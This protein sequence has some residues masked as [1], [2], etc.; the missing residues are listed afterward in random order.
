MVSLLKAMTLEEKIGQLSMRNAGDS[1]GYWIADGK[2]GAI[3]NEVDTAKL[4][5]YQQ[6][7]RDSSRLGIPLLTARDVIH[8]Y[9]TIFPVPLGQAAAWNP[10][11]VEIGAQV[12]A[13]EA[14]SQGINWTFA[15]MLDV[16]RDPRWGRVVESFGEDAYLGSLLSKAMVKGFQ[17]ND[18]S[19][20][21]TIAA[22][23][24][25]Y[26]AYGW[27]EGGRDYNTANVGLPTIHD[28]IL[29]PFVSAIDAGA[30]TVMTAFQDLNGIP[31]TGHPYWVGDYL[32]HDLG[33][34]GVVVSDWESIPQMVTHGYAA[35]NVE[36]AANAAKATV[37][38]EMQSTTYADHLAALVENGRVPLAVI[39]SA[40][41]R[42]LRLK[43]SLGLFADTQRKTSFPALLAPD[44][45]LAAQEMAT[46]SFILL[47]NKR[48]RLP[49]NTSLSVA[50]IG[51]LADAP[52]E[53][54]G[55]WVFDGQAAD[56]VTPLSAIKATWPADKVRYSPGLRISRDQ[57]KA[58]FAKAVAA[59][60]SA[61]VALL[62]LGEESIITGE[63][64]SRADI[65]LP[66]AQEDL[67]HAIAATGT[68]IV[69]VVL[70]G[71]PLTMEGWVDKVDALFFG[72]HPG[73]MTGPAI[74][75]LLTGAENPSGK[76][77][78]TF[79]KHVGQIP[80]YY[81]HTN[82]G[83]PATP[84]S[85]VSIQDIPVKALQTSVG[86]TSHYLDYGYQPAYTFGYGL[87][88]TTFAYS[89]L[90][91]RDTLL[92]MQD[93]LTV[94]VEV[95]NTGDR[96]GQTTAQLYIKDHVGSR[97]RPVRSLQGFQKIALAPG[98]KQELTFQLPVQQLSFYT[99]ENKVAV[100]PGQFTLYI[101]EDAGA[102]L[103]QS[104]TVK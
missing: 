51:P 98:E 17:G 93:S 78:I 90:T 74:V 94:T 79:P 28:H 75:D 88:Y 76:L 31:A 30:A 42:I 48:S 82:T 4:A 80:I 10:A 95:E 32:R 71:R 56:A 63:S 66:G 21:H 85:F 3:L 26:L 47:E 67:V 57:S 89:A 5:R 100:E 70:A 34:N 22:C 16:S 68:P 53:Q 61:D 65:R 55:T 45:L 39:D 11:L 103:H 54:L 25:H 77:P 6:I 50:V 44:H 84:Q 33:F 62:F 24:K 86:N 58:G 52:H 87:S 15:P 19:L 23:A 7:A 18:L 97:V 99:A 14:A 72:F 73:T 104:F 13:V 96:A 59:A 9:R 1:L 91:L 64:H 81:N 38:M 83:K 20:P 40:V 41:L 27:A 2:V 92:G 37:D 12:A 35:N 101:G 36:S 43:E 69:A 29:P 8:G 49:I 102:S 46:E 60:Q